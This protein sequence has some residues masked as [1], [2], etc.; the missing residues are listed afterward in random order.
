LFSCI[1]WLLFFFS[2]YNLL[3]T[4]LHAELYRPII[5]TIGLLLVLITFI[6]LFALHDSGF[7]FITTQ[8]FWVISSPYL[9]CLFISIQFYNLPQLYFNQTENS[10]T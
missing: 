7:T 10:T 3:K 6:T 2:I 8:L 9:I 1:T 5:Q 4:Y